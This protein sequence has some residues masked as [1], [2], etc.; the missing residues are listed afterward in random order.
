MRSV[1]IVTWSCPSV[2]ASVNTEPPRSGMPAPGLNS[3]TYDSL[4]QI[5]ALSPSS[6]LFDREV[7]RVPLVA[8][9]VQRQET[10]VARLVDR[11]VARLP[12]PPFPLVVRRQHGAGRCGV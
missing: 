7:H 10:H 12:K 9:L 8:D 1:Q 5:R 11:P 3:L 6:S 2:E 4:A